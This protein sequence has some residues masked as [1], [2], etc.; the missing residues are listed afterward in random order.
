MYNKTVMDH[1]RNPRNVGVI[2]NAD[3][4]G[5]V[6]NPLCGDMMLIESP[7]GPESIGN[8][9]VGHSGGRIICL[10]F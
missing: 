9:V 4:I 5:E 6:G 8:D 7:L 3:G 1:F 10:G 2:E